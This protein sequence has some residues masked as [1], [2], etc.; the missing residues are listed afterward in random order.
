M[1]SPPAEGASASQHWNAIGQELRE[2]YSRFAFEY[3]AST[4]SFETYP[5]LREEILAFLEIIP[6]GIILDVGS[7]SGRDSRLVGET[8]RTAVLADLSLSMLRVSGAYAAGARVC[9]DIGALPF[10][11]RTFAGI[12]ASGVILHLPRAF[13]LFA[14]REIERL[15]TIGGYALISM[16]NGEGEGWRTSDNFPARRWFSYY[17]PDEFSTLCVSAG[18]AVRY[19]DVGGRRDWF[20]VTV[21]PANIS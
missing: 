18:L 6:D 13:C 4:R 17:A 3:A 9:C 7:G 14:L 8:G 19:M 20:T 10:R 15:L 1:K 16:K 11:A 12:I 21:G 5:G 2:S